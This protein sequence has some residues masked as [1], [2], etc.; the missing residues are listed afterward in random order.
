MDGPA[1]EARRL[2]KVF[3]TSVRRPGF[4]GALRSLVA[5]ERA[6]TVAVEEVSFSV[7]RGE[8]LA[9]LGPNGAGKS[10]TIK[11]LAGVLVPSDGEARVAGQVPHLDRKVNARRIGAVFGQRTQLWWDLPAVESF[12]M[13]R[14]IFKIEQEAYRTRLEELDGLLELA[15]F[16]Q[17][18][19]RQMSLGQRVRCD[20]AAA[21]LHDPPIIFLDEPTIGMDAVAKEQVREFIRYQVEQRSR[22]VILTTHDMAEV[23]RLARRV[24]LVNEGR[25]VYDGGLAEL[26]KEY[27]SG[28]KVRVTFA[29]GEVP[30]GIPGPGEKV[31]DAHVFAGVD[32]TAKRELMRSL[33]DRDDVTDL[34]THGD[35]LEDIMAAV[36]RKRAAVTA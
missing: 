27:G 14:D 21:L 28:W 2:R 20:L 36:Y 9:L 32:P 18:R 35:D 6:D 34:E 12:T 3:T 11:M 31:G 30:P 26:Q 16:W 17:R 1:I 8:L 25:V 24:L 23:A 29:T 5:P 4:V 22:T 33:L 15:S 10:T 19:P 7:A 13:L